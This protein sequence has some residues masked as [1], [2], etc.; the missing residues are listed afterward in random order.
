MRTLTICAIITTIFTLSIS[1]A[2]SDDDTEKS[3]Y[4][5]SDE[6]ISIYPFIGGYIFEGNQEMDSNAII[7]V[8][9]EYWYNKN[10]SNLLSIGYGKFDCGK[11]YPFLSQSIKDSS[12]SFLVHYDALYH[13]SPEKYIPT[14][15]EPL[16][17][18]VSLGLGLLVIDHDYLADNDYP[19]VNYGSGL[20]WYFSKELS[21]RVDLR[22]MISVDNHYN[23]LNLTCGFVYSWDLGNKP[24]KKIETG[25]MDD[26]KDGVINE[27][28]QCNF[29]PL[30]VKVDKCG[31]A[32]DSDNDGVKDFQ[33]KCLD[34]PGAI[35]NKLGCPKDSDH[36]GIADF[37]DECP[38]TSSGY[39][40]DSKGCPP[41]TD[42]DGIRDDK[43]QCNDTPQNMKVD[44]YGCLLQ[45]EKL[46]I[47]PLII[48]FSMD[49]SEIPLKYYEKIKELASILKYYSQSTV[50]IDAYTDDLGPSKYNLLLSERRAKKVKEF[51]VDT[52]KINTSK[53]K[54]IPHGE[55]DPIGDN[56]TEE[57]RQ[58]NRRVI[59]SITNVPF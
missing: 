20:D 33:D 22:H 8:G 31:C 9:G 26:D 48:Q 53:I 56:I 11:Y 52:F 43:D 28:D 6:T 16:V 38:T 12:N 1:Q 24:K 57:G 3:Q 51:I 21:L 47:D 13:F 18:Y 32:L 46:K 30:Y 54:V 34:F 37:K 35:V 40:V 14:W 36:D 5:H 45:F 29:T 49:S 58:K 50:K 15:P 7:G 23:N 59:I 2:F 4:F 25:K 44:A 55:S 17:P 42:N 39:S 10:F 41:D 27:I 19:L